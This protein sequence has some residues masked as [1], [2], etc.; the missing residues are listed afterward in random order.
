MKQ[1]FR[2]FFFDE[3]TRPWLVLFC[4][5]LSGFAEAISISAILPAMQAL[6]SDGQSHS[7]LPTVY[8]H[9][10]LE[11]IGV[12][13][14]SLN[15]IIVVVAFFSMKTML[16]FFAM[17][18][19]GIAVARVSTGFRRRI[20]A[21]V[22]NARWSY[23]TQLQTGRLANTISAEATLRGSAYSIAAQLVS[24]SMQG[25]AYAAVALLIDWRLALLG[26]AAGL[27]ITAVLGW[28][29]KISRRAGYKRADRS[30]SLTKFVADLVSNF[31]P[32]K[33]MHRYD[34]LVL[35]IGAI[36]RRLRKALVTRE[37]ARQGLTQGSELLLTLALGFGAYFAIAFG[38]SLAELV[39]LGVVFFQM[40]AIIS[41]L[42]KLLQEAA[43][44]EAAYVR[45]EQFLANALEQRE[46]H[47]GDKPPT[48]NQECRFE[49]VSFSHG[50]TPVINEASFIIKTGSVTVLQGVSGV[51]KTTLVDLLLG[52]HQPDSGR[53]TLD[54]VPL[55][56]IDILQ[57]RR[58]IGYVAQ[59]LSLLHGTIR[60][61]IVLGNHDVSDS[62][63]EAALGQA[64]ALEF[65]R[66]MPAGL[67][68]DV[69][70]MGLKLSGGQRQRVALARALVLNPQ[71]LI[72]DEVTSAL[73]PEAEREICENISSLRGKYTTIAITHRPAWAEI[74][75]DLYNVGR[76]G[77]AK[78]E[79]SLSKQARL[80]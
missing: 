39:V 67:E 34:E 49:N 16:T 29:V 9:K 75:T 78:V 66:A 3:D 55:D 8:V 33:A 60:E 38:A 14:T 25:L 11:G 77:V 70:S 52:L 63:I 61:N 47:T 54:G 13:P 30:S 41:K 40:I 17:S 50:D 62:D 72:L 59:E 2:I 27:L 22:F 7:S 37:I 6:A 65:I 56:K 79:S 64:G 76:K 53:I 21:A 46:V 20:I 15:L 10:I 57:W 45:S 35:E 42:Q 43:D 32:L 4:L 26:A 58:S 18:Y 12:A 5:V 44:N 19:A 71:L 48:L 69:G 23:Y 74:A 68:T 1:V 31:K 28:L 24:Y 80:A 36:L 51:G 73:D